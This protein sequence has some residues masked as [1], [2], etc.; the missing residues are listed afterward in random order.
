LQAIGASVITSS[1]L[2]A[3]ERIE[4]SPNGYEPF[5]RPLIVTR[6]NLVKEQNKKAGIFRSRPLITYSKIAG[7]YG[8]PR[9]VILTEL[10]AFG[11]AARLNLR[12]MIE[13]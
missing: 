7:I 12:I 11:F 2:V 8:A 1:P 3:G 10:V 6:S 13:I 5:H 9:A 4:R